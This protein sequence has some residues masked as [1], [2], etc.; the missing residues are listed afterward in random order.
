M[1][2]IKYKKRKRKSL[3]VEGVLLD[4]QRQEMREVQVEVNEVQVEGKEEDIKGISTIKKN[5][6]IIKDN[7]VSHTRDQDTFENV[8]DFALLQQLN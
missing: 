5:N 4:R 7:K 6:H 1:L 3:V 2:E 8:L